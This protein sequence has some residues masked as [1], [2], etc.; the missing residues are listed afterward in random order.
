MRHTFYSRL[1]QIETFLAMVVL[2]VVAVATFSAM[3]ILS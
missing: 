2:T 1:Q 3:F